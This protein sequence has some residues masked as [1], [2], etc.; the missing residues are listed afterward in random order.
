MNPNGD[1][2][3]KN[4]GVLYTSTADVRLAPLF[5]VVS[6]ALYR[7]RRFDGGPEFE[8]NTLA[9]RMFRGKSYRSRSYPLHDELLRF[10]SAV[11]GVNRPHETLERIAQGMTET[12]SV[13]RRDSRIAGDLWQQMTTCWERG[14]GYAR[15]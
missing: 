15:R 6:T 3:L 7:Y 1:A 2:H 13:L 12:L 4:F 11:C 9:L 10:G 14:L 5:D 8:D